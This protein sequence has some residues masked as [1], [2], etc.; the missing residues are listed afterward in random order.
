MGRAGLAGVLERERNGRRRPTA[1]VY[2]YHVTDDELVPTGLGRDL[3]RDYAT[4][5]VDVTWAEVTADEHLSGAF[6]GASGAVDWL[7]QTLPALPATARRAV[8]GTVGAH[9]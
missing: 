8:S 7:A 9:E 6:V 1:P 3:F 5:G 4:L 2:L